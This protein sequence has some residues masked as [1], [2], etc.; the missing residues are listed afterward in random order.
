MK[1]NANH[2]FIRKTIY[3]KR[4][5]AKKILEIAKKDN[6]TFS[7]YVSILLEAITNGKKYSL[8]LTLIWQRTH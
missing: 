7:N 1:K 3:L 8:V 2:E 5:V 6:R 4:D